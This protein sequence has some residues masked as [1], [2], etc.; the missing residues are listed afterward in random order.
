MRN[1]ACLSNENRKCM[2]LAIGKVS[3]NVVGV[4]SIQA[5]KALLS[6]ESW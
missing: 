1:G 4:F 5:A 3:E 6:V 2:P